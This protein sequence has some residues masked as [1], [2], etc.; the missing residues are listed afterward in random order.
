MQFD[1]AL[2]LLLRWFDYFDSP[3]PVLAIQHSCCEI[4]K[5][6]AVLTC[7]P[8]NAYHCSEFKQ[9]QRHGLQ[10]GLWPHLP[11][12]PS[13]SRFPFLPPLTPLPSLRV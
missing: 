10:E 13:I 1:A 11:F 3:R 4:E 6:G 12:T 8:L 2:Q 9:H 5:V 7:M